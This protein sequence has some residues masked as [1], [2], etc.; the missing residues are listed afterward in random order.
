MII[1][2]VGG[3]KRRVFLSFDTE[4]DKPFRDF[5]INQ[6]RKED[7]TWAVT[8]WSEPY[9]PGDSMWVS[10]TTQ[11]IK[12]AE[13]LIVLLG[14]GTFRCTGVLKE[15][16]IAQILE[17]NI[18]QIIPAAKGTPHILPNVG[19]IVRWDWNNVKR[20]IA[21]APRPWGKASQVRLS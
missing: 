8:R 12:Q 14:P 1:K 17:K 18:F 15:V 3:V 9:D 4:R 19:K 21:T 11:R 6:G 20:A 16:T 10:A 5:F 13:V 2:T 7:A